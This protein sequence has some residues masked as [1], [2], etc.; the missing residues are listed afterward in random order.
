MDTDE[1]NAGKENAS[2]EPMERVELVSLS[3][4]KA[5]VE[6]AITRI[7]LLHLAF[8]RTF[9]EEFG[10]EKGKE[11]ITKSILQYGR[12][13]GER[14]KRGLVDYPSA[15][16]GAYVERSHDKIYDCVL[17]RIFREYDALG[18]GG[19]YCYVDPAKTMA[20]NPAVKLI[21]ND[22]AACGDDYCTFAEL[23]TTEKERN[24]FTNACSDWKYVDPRLARGAMKR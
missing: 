6:A 9:M 21:H 8:S 5:Q 20:A 18:L 19:L 16:Y 15:R 3:E 17:A 7:A 11:L 10:S 2:V 12:W 4:A 13:V 23:P 24:D 1:S 14:I 22:C